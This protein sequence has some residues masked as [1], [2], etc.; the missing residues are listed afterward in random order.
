MRRE[1][2]RDRI[3]A[4]GGLRVYFLSKIMA[5]LDRL[6]TLSMSLCLGDYSLDLLV[7]YLLDK[8]LSMCCCKDRFGLFLLS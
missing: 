4:G 2:S 7:C 1:S 5:S 3:K 8:C 6:T